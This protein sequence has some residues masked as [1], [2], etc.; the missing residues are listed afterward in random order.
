[1]SMQHRA[2]ME[3]AAA[4]LRRR[5]QPGTVVGLASATS[6]AEGAPVRVLADGRVPEG[7]V[8]AAQDARLFQRRCWACERPWADTARGSCCPFCGARP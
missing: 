4:Q 2:R 1:M 5:A 8:V 6:V 3:R 7:V